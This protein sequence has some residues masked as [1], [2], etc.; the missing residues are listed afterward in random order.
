MAKS[1]YGVQT[2]TNCISLMMLKV[3]QM[4]RPNVEPPIIYF[5]DEY[6]SSHANPM[7]VDE[8]LINNGNFHGEYLAKGKNSVFGSILA[9]L[10]KWPI[11]LPT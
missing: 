11:N 6:G 2:E 5:L 1:L 8:T 4:F 3:E 9:T 10:K 7:V